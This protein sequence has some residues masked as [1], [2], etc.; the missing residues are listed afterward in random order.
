[1]QRHSVD[2]LS[3]MEIE[4]ETGSTQSLQFWSIFGPNLTPENQKYCQK[5]KFIHNLHPQDY[6]KTQVPSP[7]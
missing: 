3:K 6:K 4:A 1:M 2:N 7:R 5:P